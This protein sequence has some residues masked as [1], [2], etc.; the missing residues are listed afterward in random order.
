MTDNIAG[1][2]TTIPL[3]KSIRYESY[4]FHA[5]SEPAGGITVEQLFIK[6]TLYILGWIRSRCRDTDLPQEMK[7]IPEPENFKT[8]G[9]E[10]IRSFRHDL[11]YTLEVHFSEDKKTWAIQITEPDRGP[12]PENPKENR[13]P[14]PGRLFVT[15]IGLKIIDNQKIEIGS[16]TYVDEPRDTSAECDAFRQAFI[17]KFLKD[18]NIKLREDWPVKD[19]PFLIKNQ[20]ALDNLSDW[21]ISEERQS[22]AVIFTGTKDPIIETATNKNEDINTT[23]KKPVIQIQNSEKCLEAFN[24]L[25]HNLVAYAFFFQIPEERRTAFLSKMKFTV[26]N[27]DLFLIEANKYGYTV[28]MYSM[29]DYLSNDDTYNEVNRRIKKYFE[30]RPADFGKV[31]FVSDIREHGF[32]DFMDVKRSKEEIV[33]EHEKLLNDIRKDHERELQKKDEEIERFKNK[34]DVKEYQCKVTESRYTELQ[35]SSDTDKEKFKNKITKLEESLER[36]KAKAKR[37][38]EFRF[39]CK[40]VEENFSDH[41]I[42]CERAQDEIG[43]INKEYDI[44]NICD[45]IGYLAEDYYEK[46]IGSISEDEM[47]NRCSE[48]YNER[49]NITALTIPQKSNKK[50]YEFKYIKR[51][52]SPTKAKMDQHIYLDGSE[53]R[54][55]FYFDKADK[56]IIIASLP[57]HL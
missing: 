12:C 6:E 49:I 43:K 48:K 9:L 52:G 23:D 25:A 50:D 53:G 39:F 56:R 22:L 19:T 33:I 16:R 55:Y 18:S 13:V 30:K 29:S 38:K 2:Y 1:A 15:D 26:Q 54:I 20:D 46:L 11:G 27:E 24:K 47:K 34:L 51:N 28:S 21:L 3:V 35:K 45:S 42:L 36:E 5:F 4:Q 57:K 44:D 10:D 37:P 41:L 14:V 31:Q 40:W 32:S 17:K 8:Y 7:D